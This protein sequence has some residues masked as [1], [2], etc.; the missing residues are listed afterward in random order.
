[1]TINFSY[2]SGINKKLFDA[3]GCDATQTS[4][5]TTHSKQLDCFQL[6]HALAVSTVLCGCPNRE[7]DCKLFSVA[8]MHSKRNLNPPDYTLPYS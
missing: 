2:F 8:C 1:M 4:L 6:V 7:Y 3:K 5:T